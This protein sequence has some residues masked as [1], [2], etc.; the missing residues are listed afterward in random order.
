MRRYR[1]ASPFGKKPCYGDIDSFQ[2]QNESKMTL[3]DVAKY[4]HF[5]Q[6]STT[7][8]SMST[9]TSRSMDA[10]F[11][12]SRAV[13]SSPLPPMKMLLG[14]PLPAP[15]TASLLSTA[16]QNMGGWTR[17]SWYTN[18]RDDLHIEM[19][20]LSLKS[21]QSFEVA[22][23]EKQE[24]YTNAQCTHLVVLG[25]LRLAVSDERPTEVSVD[26][27]HLLKLGQRRVVNRMQHHV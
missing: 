4:T 6:T 12:T 23:E 15:P 8:G 11:R 25:A 19:C 5:L 3:A 24:M 2:M 7:S 21:D 26:D 13:A 22:R 18:F 1:L 20:K 27:L 17:L 10:C 9:M 16:L 14:P